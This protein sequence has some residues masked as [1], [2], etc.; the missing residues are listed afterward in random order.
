[1]TRNCLLVSVLI[2]A[3][4]P[5]RCDQQFQASGLVLEVD[6]AHQTITIS[7]G[8]IPGFMDA[9]VMPFHVK[10]PKALDQVHAAMMIDFRLFVTKTASYISD[11]HERKF[12]SIEA[13]PDQARRLKV[14][15]AALQ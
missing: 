15:D 9:M 11:I 1:M 7:H 4:I 5:A 12:E 13:D 6:K 14:L 8:S 10:D 2:A 3:V